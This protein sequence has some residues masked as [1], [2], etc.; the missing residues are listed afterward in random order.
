MSETEKYRQIFDSFDVDGSGGISANELYS[1]LT[2][3][4]VSCSRVEI[5]NLIK[6]SDLNQN[7]TIEFD[8]FLILIDRISKGEIK[9]GLAKSFKNVFEKK[10]EKYIL[11][12]FLKK[13]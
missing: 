2:Q 6:E 3:A 4:G 9:S 5:E 1:A 12:F 7:S 8:E 11:L 10:V 13:S